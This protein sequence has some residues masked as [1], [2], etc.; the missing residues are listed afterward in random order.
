M[1]F[2]FGRIIASGSMAASL[3]LP[4]SSRPLARPGAGQRD[5]QRAW[6]GK[7]KGVGRYAT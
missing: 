4:Q 6:G 1:R 7:T 3:T 2:G 5:A